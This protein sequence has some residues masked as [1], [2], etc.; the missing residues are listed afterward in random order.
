MN[1]EMPPVSCCS[2][3]QSI[4]VG[5]PKCRMNL[6]V[7]LEQLWWKPA[8]STPQ[9]SQFGTFSR[10]GLNSW[11]ENGLPRKLMGYHH[12]PHSV[13]ILGGIRQPFQDKA[14]CELTRA[15]NSSWFPGGFLKQRC[16]QS[17][18]SRWD[19]PLNHPAGWG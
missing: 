6:S 15:W 2:H 14:G 13:A 8:P 16:P 3:L 11:F 10:K 9:S 5:P 18:I 19:V 12:F 17:S 1:A 4:M 7:L